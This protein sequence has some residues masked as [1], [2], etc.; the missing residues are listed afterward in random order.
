MST[1][2]VTVVVDT[3]EA[4]A[5]D[6]TQPVQV[7]Y[8]GTQGAPGTIAL[9]A[10]N[11]DPAAH[12]GATVRDGLPVIPLAIPTYDGNV[13]VLHP[14]V[15]YVPEGWNGYRYWLAFTPYPNAGRE[16]PSVVASND[17]ATWVVPAGLTNPVTSQA[18]SV[19]DGYAFNSD[20]HLMRMPN[21]GMAL[22]YRPATSATKNAVYRKTSS[23]GITWAN[24]T[25]V[26]VDNA[27]ELTLLSPAIELEADNTYT[28]WVVDGTTTPATIR[29]R[30]SADGLTWS[31]PGACTIPAGAPPWHIDVK[32][33]G[34][35]YY[36]LSS[37][38]ELKQGDRCYFY[39]SVDG[40]TWT[41]VGS[42]LLPAVHLTGFT[43]DLIRHY[44][45]AL[46]PVIGDPLH[47]HV[48]VSG[49]ADT[50]DVNFRIGLLK[51][52]PLPTW[53]MKD[54]LAALN[55]ERS[56]GPLAIAPFFAGDN[57]N[58]TDSATTLGTTT[59]GQAWSALSGLIGLS[60]GKAYAPS[61]NAR[62][63]FESLVADVEIS[64]DFEAAIEEAWILLRISDDS[65]WWRIGTDGA[66][67]RI[68]TEKRVAGSIT[69]VSN[70][71]GK[72]LRIGDR[73]KV[74]ALG[75]VITVYRNNEQISTTTDAFNATATKHGI[76]MLGANVR[77]DNLALKVP[78]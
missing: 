50:G 78:Q 69:T 4:G 11:V 9:A 60:K 62:W 64:I 56:N 67:G 48:F 76:G 7:V 18:E 22:Y 14:S 61:G 42:P 3:T 8:L 16:N 35:I 6:A 15:V 74:R 27:A 53:G 33:V 31:A 40:I 29:R 46:V 55:Q 20:T 17:L 59:T 2:N 28:M 26:V 1:L 5:L 12:P 38:N 65:N 13:N 47:W 70:L 54:L 45:S 36:M 43:F 21:G 57:F 77:L 73:L 75:S 68:K 37:T 25:A 39:S 19:A 63:N 30:T 66:T 58:R 32:R 49:I 52:V 34:S 23:D 44:R 72:P 24:K 41:A 71:T 10:H 51:D